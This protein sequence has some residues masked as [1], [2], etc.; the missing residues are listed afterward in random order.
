MTFAEKL[1]ELRESKKLSQKELA[2]AAGVTQAT[3][4]RW[5]SGSQTPGF[6]DAM[7]LCK[8]LGVRCTA[9]EGCEFNKRK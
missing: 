5:E 8:A 2:E 6:P 1:K 3:L 7:S 4:S 9:F